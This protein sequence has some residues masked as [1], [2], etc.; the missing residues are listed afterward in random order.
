MDIEVVLISGDTTLVR[1]YFSVENNII[2]GLYNYNDIGA[3]YMITPENFPDYNSY[4]SDNLDN[5]QNPPP[6]YSITDNIFDVDTL[7]FSDN[8]GINFIDPSLFFS[9]IQYLE[10]PQTTQHTLRFPFFNFYS[11]DYGDGPVNYFWAYDGP[12]YG[13]N[14]ILTNSIVIQ[15]IFDEP[16]PTPE[17]PPEPTPEPPPPEPTP[18][19][20]ISNICFVAGTKINTNKGSIP[21]QDI[22]TSTQTINGKKIVAITRTIAKDTFLVCFKRNSI[23]KNIPWLIP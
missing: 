20:P 18:T 19:V 3:N 21:I 8:S 5:S 23:N 12:D 15:E 14:D 13:A 17:P 9:P 7:L 22:D 4:F 11:A 2:Q 16:Q 1:Y 6:F 10:V